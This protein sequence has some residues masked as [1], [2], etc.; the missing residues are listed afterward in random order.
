MRPLA[1]IT[2][3][4]VLVLQ[5]PRL[6]LYA[7]PH[8]PSLLEVGHAARL[9]TPSQTPDEIKI[10][11]YN[12]RWRGGEDLK[13]LAHLFKT[14]VEIGGASILGLQEVDR[15]RKRTRNANTVKVL[16]DDLGM[17]YAWAAPPTAP[18]EKEEETGVAI[19]S[20]YPLTHVHRIVLPHAG[21][22]GRRRAA[23]GATV[24]IGSKTLR[25]YSV[26]SENRMSVTKKL[27][28]Y[29]SVLTEAERLDKHMPIIVLGDFNTW[30]GDA[31]AKTNKLFAGA[32]FRTPF[33][34]TSTF[35]RQVLFVPIEF[36]LDWIWL[37]NLETTRHGIDKDIGISD[38]WPLWAVVQLAQ[39]KENSN[40]AGTK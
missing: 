20:F 2:L 4:I 21:P 38:H 39:G 10:I 17:Y 18:G 22:G 13:K 35:C 33:N 16:A 19:L 23:I 24:T 11:S 1:L 37:K 25:V 28:Q 30:E 26:H 3:T 36:K 8:G 40:P 7:R 15:N 5:S 32:S 12:I 34:N 27:D 31:V 9:K 14:D 29:Q 6:L